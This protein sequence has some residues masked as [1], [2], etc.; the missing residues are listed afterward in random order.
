MDPMARIKGYWSL[1]KTLLSNKKIP[2]IPPLL[3]N[4]KYVT[5]F[6]KKAELFSLFFAEQCSKIDNS[7]KIPLNFLKKTRQ[8][9]FCNYFFL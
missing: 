7:S 2:C 6:R 1:S 3:Q 8:I 9:Y 4:K 5:D